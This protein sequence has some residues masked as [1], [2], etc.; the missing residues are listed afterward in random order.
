M[1]LDTVIIISKGF[2]FVVVGIFTPWIAALAQWANS[3]DSP[4]RIIWLGVIM[5]LSFIGAGNAWISFTSGS[6]KEY[7]QQRL[8]DVTGETQTTETKPAV[9]KEDL[10]LEPVKPKVEP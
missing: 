8:A 7:R 10:T 3:G 2:A 9:P 5:P 6:W 1:K 4:P